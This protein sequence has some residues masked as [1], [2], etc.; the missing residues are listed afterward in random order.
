MAS[1]TS[2]CDSAASWHHAGATKEPGIAHVTP[3]TAATTAGC[4]ARTIRSIAG[5]VRWLHIALAATVAVASASRAVQADDACLG[6]PDGAV[7]LDDDDPCTTDRCAA[8]ACTHADV[9]N[10]TTCE[11]VLD[12]YRRTLGLGDLVDELAADLATAAMPDATRTVVLNGLAAAATD[13]G[14]ASDAL[15]GRI[16]VPPPGA[17]ETLAQARARVAFAVARLIPGN[18]RPVAR[19]LRAPDV[20]AAIGPPSVDLARRVRFLYRS[21]NQFKRELRRLQRVSGAFAR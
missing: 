2:S 7:C 6:V 14:R 20:R 3:M 17:G 9:P 10:R 5:H 8:G 4:R 21:T 19:A 12:A 18:V 1:Y 13:L 11:P 15:A 16:E